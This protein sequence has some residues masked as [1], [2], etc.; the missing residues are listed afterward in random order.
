MP[1]EE[2]EKNEFN[3]NIPRY[4]DTQEEED[5]QDLDA[6][7]NGGIPAR[8]VEGLKHYWDVFPSLREELFEPLRDSYYS[9]KIPATEI[10][11]KIFSNPE[12]LA[13]RQTIDAV[14]NEFIENNYEK[15]KEINS[16]TSPKQFIYELAEDILQ[17]YAD[18]PLI[19]RYDVYQHVLD[20]WM[21][22][23]KDDVYLIVE[24]GWDARVR[25][26]IEENKKGKKIDKGWTSDL[27]PK[28]L[29]IKSYLTDKEEQ[30]KQ[31]ETDLES[32]QAE[33][34]QYEEEHGCEEGLLSE[35]T[36]DKGKLTKGTV[37][38]Q[39]KQIKNDP[40]EKEAYEMMKQVKALFEKET[41]L[42]KQIKEVTE[43]LDDLLLKQYKELTEADVKKLVVEDKW[44][45][46]LK[47]DIDG[48]VDAISQRLT[49]RIKELAERYE[50]TLS[51]LTGSVSELE[52]KVN[53]H[54]QKMGLVWN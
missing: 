2:I 9:L 51:E 47:E 13:Y 31:L 39:M 37:V 52:V 22:T 19:N 18:K 3:L 16:E 53:G 27:L 28:P 5:I 12:F 11:E 4:I 42:K 32:V 23:M 24:E 1:F 10:K 40:E 54:L 43:G 36:N 7:L 35:A 30:L 17:R 33:L 29:V 20:Y 34:V 6:H 48:E 14:F 41:D 21:A 50:H 46:E 8:D 15:L 25:R 26:I 49:G 38:A 45:T 44:L